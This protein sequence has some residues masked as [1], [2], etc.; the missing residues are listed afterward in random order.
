MKRQ[1]QRNKILGSFASLALH[2]L[3]RAAILLLALVQIIAPMWHVCSM[4]GMT[5]HDPEAQHSVQIWKPKCGGGLQCPCVKPAGA[6][7]SPTGQWYSAPVDDAFHGTC[8][9]RLL[10]GMPGSVAAPF[11][12]TVL[13]TRRTCFAPSSFQSPAVATFA[14]NPLPVALLCFASDLTVVRNSTIWRNTCN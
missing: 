2:P 4:S 10:M 11:D 13:F 9:A 12:F 3:G 5:C 14:A 8:L 6:L 7:Y 1:P